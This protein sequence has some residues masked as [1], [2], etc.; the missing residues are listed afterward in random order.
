MPE[1]DLAAFQKLVEIL[2]PMFPSLQKLYL[3]V[4]GDMKRGNLFPD[5]IVEVTES[6]I[7]EPLDD[8]VRRLGRQLQVCEI[9]VPTSLYASRKY[10]TTGKRFRPV[11]SRE[12]FPRRER[13][14]RVVPKALMDD[15][16]TESAPHRNGYWLHH[17]QFD[18]PHL[19]S[20]GMCAAMDDHTP[21]SEDEN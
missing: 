20:S 8:L 3:S 2:P 12:G 5:D 21:D 17:G 7:M 1:T 15:G 16:N 10:A 13:F 4:Q 18:Q 9:A 11:W 14:W 19:F 6:M